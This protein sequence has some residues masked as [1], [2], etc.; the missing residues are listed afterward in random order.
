M[1]VILVIFILE[2]TMHVSKDLFMMVLMGRVRELARYFNNFQEIPSWPILFFGLSDVMIFMISFGSVG[3]IKNRLC[4]A[5][6]K[7]P[8]NGLEVWGILDANSGPISAKY[9]QNL[10]ALVFGSLIKFAPT[11]VW[12]NVLRPPFCTLLAKLGRMIY[13]DE[14][15]LKEKPE[16]TRYIKRLHQIYAIIRN[17]RLGSCRSWTPEGSMLLRLRRLLQL[18]IH[19]LKQRSHYKKLL[20]WIIG[21]AT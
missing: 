5:C 13:D 6:F 11:C 9:W 3:F 19:L 17:C 1:G 10:S 20:P 14:V 16:E 2:G 7:C 18:E 15:G 21:S 8:W 4:L 12:L